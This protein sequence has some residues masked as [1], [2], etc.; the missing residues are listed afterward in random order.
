M[1]LSV[2][3]PVFKNLDINGIY[4]KIINSLKKIKYE[5]IF[6]SCE[7][8]DILND[9]YEKDM[10][11]IKIIYLSKDFNNN[12]L[13]QAGLDSASGEYNIVIDDNF[14]FSN[15]DIMIKELDDD[16]NLDIISTGYEPN[17]KDKLDSSGY[18]LIRSNVREAIK[19]YKYSNKVYSMIG[20]NT[21]YM[22][23]DININKYSLL[24]EINKISL[25]CFGISLLFL[26]ILL[27]TL[28]VSLVV[29]FDTIYLII[30]IILFNISIEFCL[31]GNVYISKY[32]E[33]YDKYIIKNKIGFGD[34]D[35]L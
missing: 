10:L 14:D 16:S 2:I 17:I 20:F 9:L 11:H 25:W 29:G 5:I 33:K 4:D 21:K 15:L 6:V 19:E 1:K 32:K 30:L 8:D 22:S 7:N 18:R 35:I 31:F 28:I 23:K 3:I 34:K 24:K 27:I 26:V 13:I 12:L